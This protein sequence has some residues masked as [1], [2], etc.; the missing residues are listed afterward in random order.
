MR[1]RQTPVMRSAIDIVVSSKSVVRTERALP[2]HELCIRP[3]GSGKRRSI[4]P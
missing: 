3:P 2:A 4:P 1:T